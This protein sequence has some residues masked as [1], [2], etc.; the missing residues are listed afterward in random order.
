MPQK[1]SCLESRCFTDAECNDGEKCCDAGMCFQCVSAINQKENWATSEKFTPTTFGGIPT[2]GI[3]TH[4]IPTHGIP[5]HGFSTHGFSTHGIPTH[6]GFSTGGFSTRGFSHGS[7]SGSPTSPF[8]TAILPSSTLMPPPVKLAAGS[9]IGQCQRPKK[10]A[11]L[12]CSNEPAKPDCGS[13]SDCTRDFERCCPDACGI[14]R[15]KLPDVATS[16]IILKKIFEKN[17]NSGNNLIW[18]KKQKEN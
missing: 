18:K 8:A 11:L 12:D 9:N 1:K 16:K 17:F 15:C 2:N 3:P 13:D 6:G 14:S 4:G 7:S 10:P 5:A